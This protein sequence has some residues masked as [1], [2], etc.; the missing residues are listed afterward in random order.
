MIKSLPNRKFVITQNDK[1]IVETL[2]KNWN[3]K[4]YF[5][6]IISLSE[7]DVSKSAL[8]TKIGLAPENCVLFDDCFD[9]VIDAIDKTY[10]ICPKILLFSTI[11]A[12]ICC[13]IFL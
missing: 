4:D 7:S 8:I 9:F 10:T 12:S 1:D 5:Q 3:L 6:N 11:L 2:L 13:P